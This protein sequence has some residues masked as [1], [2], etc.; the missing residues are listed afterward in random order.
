MSSDKPVTDSHDT[1]RFHLNKR[2]MRVRYENETEET[3]DV[4]VEPRGEKEQQ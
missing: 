3:V 4:V 2:E 1:Y